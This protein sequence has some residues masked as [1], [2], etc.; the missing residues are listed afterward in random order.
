MLLLNEV[1]ATSAKSVLDHLVALGLTRGEA[2]L[3]ELVG[4]GLR[5]RDAAE[6]IGLTE[7]S[8]RTVLKRAYSKLDIAS[9]S[10]LSVL[11]TKLK[12]FAPSKNGSPDQPG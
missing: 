1:G 2:R 6:R 8:A 7:G 3:S 11:V 5:P 9:Q 10:E 12:M 4:S